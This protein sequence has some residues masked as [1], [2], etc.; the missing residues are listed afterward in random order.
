M[1]VVDCP[2]CCY[3]GYASFL[4][5]CPGGRMVEF[6][7]GPTVIQ[8]I[9]P[10]KKFNHIVCGDFYESNNK[11]I[12]KWLRKDKDAFDFTTSFQFHAELEGHG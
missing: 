10:S 7:S 2:K 6:G 11:E 9:S 4:D 5:T 3:H 1:E 8:L 12:E